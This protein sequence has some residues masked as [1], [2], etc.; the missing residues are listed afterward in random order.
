M[1]VSFWVCA[2]LTLIT[3]SLIA[4]SIR[5]QDQ[6]PQTEPV[7]PP[8]EPW[9][10]VDAK[11]VRLGEA[12]TITPQEDEP[13]TWQRF[14][15]REPGV[16]LIESSKKATQ[17]DVKL[18]DEVGRFVALNPALEKNNAGR[19]RWN[20]RVSPGVYF[21]AWQPKKTDGKPVEVKVLFSAFEAGEPNDQLEDAT[22]VE[23][24]QP[25]ALK[26]MPSGDVDFLAVEVTEPGV[27]T[28]QVEGYPGAD[29]YSPAFRMLDAEG[30]PVDGKRFWGRALQPGRYV[31]Q[32]WP[33][34]YQWKQ[35]LVTEPYQ[36]TVNF[37]AD[38]DTTEP[39]GSLKAAHELP[40][41]QTV[42]LTLLPRG[43]QDFIKLTPPKQGTK[44]I[45]L[46]WQGDYRPYITPLNAEGRPAGPEGQA[47]AMIRS[48]G[49][50]VYLRIQSKR[51]QSNA[52]AVK[53]PFKVTASFRRDPD[54]TEPNNTIKQARTLKFDDPIEVWFEPRDDRDVFK[55][56]S[57]V[58]GTVI[59][60]VENWNR[61]EA[62]GRWPWFQYSGADGKTYREGPWD[63]GLR[64]N[65]PVYVT[66][67]PARFA[68]NRRTV[69]TPA[70]VTATFV[71]SKDPNEP[72]YSYATATPVRFDTPVTATF[73]P[74]KDQ[75]FYRIDPPGQGV[76]RVEFD[77]WDKEQANK[78]GPWLSFHQADGTQIREGGYDVSVDGQPIFIHARSARFMHEQRRVDTPFTLTFRYEGSGDKTEPN[79]SIAQAYPVTI[80]KPIELTLKPTRDQDYLKFKFDEPGVLSLV[81]E[82]WDHKTS[83]RG[84][85]WIDFLEDEK[86]LL[87][88]GHREI[89]VKVSQLGKPIYARIQG[90]RFLYDAAL[91]EKPFIVTA[92]FEPGATLTDL[93]NPH[94]NSPSDQAPTNGTL[95]FRFQIERQDATDPS[96]VEAP[97]ESKTQPASE[98]LP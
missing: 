52:V 96:D 4:V 9:P 33:S 39:N 16:V 69:S 78:P 95:K 35:R 50:P 92:Q 11:A 77:N 19:H 84:G 46:K 36:F 34:Q 47:T 23:F 8:T 88:Q 58:A 59:F 3:I 56:E 89:Q 98:D 22:L 48:Y 91:T 85:P 49:Q 40:F 17:F 27:L 63:V 10:V 28:W 80:G 43:D 82:N 24:G 26:M 97:V 20:R 21:M 90:T 57:P 13:V 14:E 83:G 72:N 74:S 30:E 93:A 6:P 12:F 7:T 65:Q 44:L 86:T 55:L 66:M 64:P 73:S 67:L 94:P 18:Y 68:V 76:V 87:S 38:P 70:I 81:L 15:V 71:P 5:A 25:V 29:V 45:D 2:G 1:R 51:F 32:H 75:D 60:K 41:D 31:I 79:D 42:A 53:E 62:G 61:K 37:T 54:P